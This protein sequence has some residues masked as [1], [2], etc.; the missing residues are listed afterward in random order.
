MRINKIIEILLYV[1]IFCIP[2][3][4][5]IV[6]NQM[7]F[8]YI[9]GK[10]FAFRVLIII[11][12][13]LWASLAILDKKYRPKKSILLYAFIAFTLIIS[14]ADIFSINP[15]KSIWS[16]YE[17]MEGMVTILHLLAMFVVLGSFL[18]EKTWNW[19]VNFCL[20]ASVIMGFWGI[21]QLSE[22]ITR[23]YAG[24]GNSSYLGG[25]MLIH[26]FIAIYLLLKRI[27]K[28]IYSIEDKFFS[29]VYGVV[30]IFDLYVL[31]QTGTRGSLVGLVLG[32]VVTAILLAIFEKQNKILRW[33]AFSFL[34]IVVLGFVTLASIKNTDFAKNN[35]LIS[36]FSELATL[37]LKTYAE[38]AGQGRLLIWKIALKG[39]AERPLLGWG[40][41]NFGYVF[42]KYYDPQAYAQEQWFDRTHNV[43]LDWLISGGILGL[44]SYLS[45]FVAALW[46]IWRKKEF[47]I[48][49]RVGFS[50][51][52]A[53]YFAHNFFVFD[54]LSSY[55]MIVI[56]L[57]YVHIISREDIPLLEKEL[58]TDTKNILVFLVLVAACAGAF[59]LN[60]NAYLENI[61]L[62][63]SISLAV[64]PG[65]TA[66]LVKDSFDKTLSYNTFGN[67]E[68]TEQLTSYIIKYVVSEKDPARKEELIKY[69]SDKLKNEYEQDKD[70]RTI[71]FLASFYA[72]VGKADDALTYLDLANKLSPNKPSLLLTIAQVKASKN[73]LAGALEIC[74][75]LYDL[76]P[77]F[78]EGTGYC[79]VL[80]GQTG[81]NIKMDKIISEQRDMIQN[82]PQIVINLFAALK[83]WDKLIEIFQSRIN[84]YGTSTPPANLL[85]S[86]SAV[87]VKAGK[88]LKAIES[89]E[90]LRKAYPEYSQSIDNSIKVLKN[91]GDPFSM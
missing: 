15:V 87:Y 2:I 53:A 10:N 43:F 16:N 67:K 9:S 4:P 29:I 17:R 64:R 11:I 65:S 84:M 75:K 6:S 30:I 8:P 90:V 70:V 41:D 32:L 24:L 26:I 60:R 38:T 69:V 50:G 46:L 54:N 33:I 74:D 71:F 51:L 79:V 56:V 3:V 59:F 77:K 25:Y 44:L 19:Y 73:D 12:A 85:S 82:N 42:S 55:I 80:Y 58:N 86:L 37:D 66:T 35:Q 7:F 28:N 27:H 88:T 23:V 20:L 1:L 91:G 21:E 78:T 39:V 48:I 31:S 34:A 45:L 5:F 89:L 57:S 40:Q 36:R 22:N 72:Q 13:G 62:S 14:I 52:I 76:V 68:A 47:T 83:Q 49:E 63:K 61:S 18:K 81:N